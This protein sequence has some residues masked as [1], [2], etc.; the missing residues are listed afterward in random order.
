MAAS[1]I[2]GAAAAGHDAAPLD[3][4]TISTITG[5]VLGLHLT[6]STREDI[7]AHASAVHGFLNLLVREDL[8]AEIDPTVRDLIVKAYVLLAAKAPTEETP[9]FSAYAHMREVADITRRLLRVWTRRNS[10]GR[11]GSNAVRAD[12]KCP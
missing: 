8:G 12:E 9:C 1:E 4:E 7:L 2:E 10:T 5:E 3:V 11:E 6:T